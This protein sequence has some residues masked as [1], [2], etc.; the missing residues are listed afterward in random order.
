[1]RL[2]ASPAA[3]SIESVNGR[4][5]AGRGLGLFD[6]QA[7]RR[8]ETPIRLVIRRERQTLAVTLRP[9]QLT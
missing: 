8:G 3:D 6:L 9:R 7:T 1:M 4:S 2:P 5:V